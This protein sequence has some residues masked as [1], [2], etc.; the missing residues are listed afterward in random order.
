[1][2]WNLKSS[3]KS[4]QTDNKVVIQIKN[5]KIYYI[6]KNKNQRIYNT[7]K[8]VEDLIEKNK[9]GTKK[10]KQAFDLPNAPNII[11]F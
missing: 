9:K 6:G 2:F 7:R 5:K 3:L 11:L 10:V 1:M 4:I 8:E